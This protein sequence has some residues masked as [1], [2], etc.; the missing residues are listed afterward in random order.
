MR[1]TASPVDGRHAPALQKSVGPTEV[2]TAEKTMVGRAGRRMCRRKHQMFAGIDKRRLCPGIAPPQ[3]KDEIFALGTQLA[4]NGIGKGLP[5]PVAMRT[6]LV[7]PHGE[8]RVHGEYSPAAP[9]GRDCPTTEQA[10]PNHSQ[11][12]EK[13][14]TA[15]R[16][17]LPPRAPKNRL[18]NIAPD[19]DRGPAPE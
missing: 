6:G 13:Y 10:C 7:G 18:R 2:A 5:P 8:Y 14:Y 17:W 1:P 15:N 9:S 19:W 12:P 16:E 4:D 11:S 3:H